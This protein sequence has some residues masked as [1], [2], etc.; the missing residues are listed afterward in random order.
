MF[1]L[2]ADLRV[3]LH[4]EPIDLRTGINSLA[5]M[6]KETLEL[7]PLDCVFAFCNRRRGRV[8]I[9]SSGN[10]MASNTYA[11]LRDFIEII[12][13]CSSLVSLYSLE[14]DHG[15]CPAHRESIAQGNFHISIAR[16]IWGDVKIAIWICRTVICCRWD[17]AVLNSNYI[18][19]HLERARRA[20]TVTMHGL[21]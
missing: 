11:A 13:V 12:A 17:N 2:I 5:I 1:R 14:S 16:Q 10:R 18:S 6:V 21:R 4:Q 7:D 20:K 8:K 3:Y 9:L 19:N 15:V